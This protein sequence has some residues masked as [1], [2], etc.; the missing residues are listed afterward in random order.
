MVVIKICVVFHDCL[1]VINE[2]ISHNNK[3]IN[4]GWLSVGYY[5]LIFFLSFSSLKKNKDNH[6]GT[7]IYF[8]KTR[9][10]KKL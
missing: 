10:G 9:K 3:V 5:F 8:L 7:E 4:P 1:L 2:Y 6:N